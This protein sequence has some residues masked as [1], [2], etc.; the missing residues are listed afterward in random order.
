MVLRV[1]PLMVLPGEMD[2]NYSFLRWRE[3]AVIPVYELV[4]FPWLRSCAWLAFCFPHLQLGTLGTW[5]EVKE[6]VFFFGIKVLEWRV[7]E[8]KTIGLEHLESIWAVLIISTAGRLCFQFGGGGGRGRRVSPQ[9]R[10]LRSKAEGA[11]AQNSW[12]LGVLSRTD[13]GIQPQ[14]LWNRK[15]YI[16]G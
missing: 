5:R 7:H 4:R 14:A 10:Q 9:V 1:W 6:V 11:H 2:K 13:P 16:G 12:R 15:R 8:W 3:L